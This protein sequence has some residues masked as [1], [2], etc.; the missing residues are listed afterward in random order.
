MLKRGFAVRPL[1]ISHTC[2]VQFAVRVGGTLLQRIFVR[3]YGTA[4]SRRRGGRC[5]ALIGRR[6]DGSG[7]V[8]DVRSQRTKRAI[9]VSPRFLQCYAC[10][11]QEKAHGRVAVPT[12]LG[13]ALHLGEKNFAHVQMHSLA[14]L[15]QIACSSQGERLAVLNADDDHWI[16]VSKAAGTICGFVPKASVRNIETEVGTR[17]YARERERG[18]FFYSSIRD[19]CTREAGVQLQRALHWRGCSLCISID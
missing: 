5:T 6:A 8:D 16:Y 3:R 18:G 10:R 14:H 2:T 13:L 11:S 9:L 12:W 7:C 4:A 17:G 19:L 1:R 15:S